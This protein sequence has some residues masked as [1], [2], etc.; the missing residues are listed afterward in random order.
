M[1][2]YEADTNVVRTYLLTCRVSESGVDPRR[3]TIY[4]PVAPCARPG[5]SART[6][7]VV[8]WLFV[9]GMKHSHHPKNVY[10]FKH[11]FFPLLVGC[12]WRGWVMCVVTSE[13][14][15]KVRQ[16]L[17]S[18]F[19]SCCFFFFFSSSRQ[20]LSVSSTHPKGRMSSGF[21]SKGLEHSTFQQ[22][23]ISFAALSTWR[24]FLPPS[25]PLTLSLTLPEFTEP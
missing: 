11:T 10:A 23:L 14:K 13:H 12:Y 8:L 6:A 18:S 20:Q 24:V 21:V 4:A 19:R 3:L 5:Q 22:S 2:Q 7:L 16:P 17:S 15:S 1:E 9:R 25:H